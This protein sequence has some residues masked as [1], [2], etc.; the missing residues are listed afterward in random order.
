MSVI[1]FFNQRRITGL[2][3][4]LLLLSIICQIII[5]VLYQNMIKAAD[6][7]AV[8]QNRLLKQCKLKF[9]NCYQLN[10]GVVNTTIYVDKFMNRIRLGGMSLIG[11]E[12]FAGQ[13]MLLSVFCAGL[14]VCK[15]I[16]EGQSVGSLLPYYIVSL[17][18][19]YLYFSV[20]SMV[21]IAAKRRI[22]KTSM[23][24]YLE[25]HML[26][27]LQLILH[28]ATSEA[29]VK[30]EGRIALK[31]VNA[32]MNEMQESGLQEAPKEQAP[33][34]TEHTAGIKQMISPTEE[35][36]LEELLREFLA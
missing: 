15:G 24:D 3:V 10:D 20:S 1:E 36:E 22:L 18:G 4:L 14:G 23:A 17:F 12:H 29:G 30:T 34:Q 27:H 21:D 28:G 7:M 11:M 9:A 26:N 8:T 32:G 25:N 13:L 19:L 5:G 31:E 33:G 16:I 6:N 2:V 35:A